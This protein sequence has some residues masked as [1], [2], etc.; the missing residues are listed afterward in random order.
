MPMDPKTLRYAETHEWAVL[1]GDVVTIGVSAFAAE[2]LGDIT[3]VEFKKPG[4][5]VEAKGS[6]GEIES[7]KSVSD[8]YAPVAGEIVETN[9][10]AVNAALNADS[11]ALAADPY[12]TFWLV[13]LKVAPGTTLDHLKTADQY[14]EQL[15]AEGH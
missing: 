12:G 1:A 14:A 10:T 5:R 11:K 3:L 2:Q 13:K 7:V 15:A 4:T 6:L 9:D 8:V